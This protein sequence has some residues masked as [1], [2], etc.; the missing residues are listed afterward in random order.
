MIEINLLPG[1]K[2]SKRG[3]GGA[4]F[5]IDFAAIGAA[6][7]SRIKDKY[8]AAAVLIGAAV[9]GGIAFLFLAQQRREAVLREAEEKAM[10]DSARYA[11]VLLDRARAQARRDSAL[12]Q[13]NIIR[14]IDED[15]YVWA[16]VLEEVSRAMPI[17][18]WLTALNFTGTAQ[19]V[20]PAASVVK[21]P[22]PDTGRVRR[23]RRVDP[24]V[25]RDTVRVAIVGRTVD[26]QAFT[27]F[28]RSL[29][30]SPFFQSVQLMRS[31]IAVEGGK[32]VHQFNINV[33]YSRPDSLLL[34]RVPF[35]V[36]QR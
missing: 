12:I 25:P 32:D 6:F 8:L 13:L 35:T 29:E 2:K 23:T 9:I 1:A 16:H 30:D 33:M 7:S 34:R 28:M 14:A 26:L 31:E 3:G 21:M 18:T 10:A 19:G 5:S 24:V 20:K 27:R 4:G 11:V 15:R 22:L 36:T 17:Y